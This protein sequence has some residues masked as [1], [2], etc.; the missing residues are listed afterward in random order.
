MLNILPVGPPNCGVAEKL[1]VAVDPTLKLKPPP[2]AGLVG[3]PNW[4]ALDPDCCCAGSADDP[5]NENT[6]VEGAGGLAAAEPA[7]KPEKPTKFHEL[8][9]FS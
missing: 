2:D 3:A 5:P 4:N 7:L 1:G 6:P 8:N 9:F